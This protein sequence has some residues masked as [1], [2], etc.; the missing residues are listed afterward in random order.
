MELSAEMK[1][2]LDELSRVNGDFN[3]FI[4]K[5][6][7]SLKSNSFKDLKSSDEYKLQAWPTFLKPQTK[8]L[9]LEMGT[10]VFDL[11]KSIPG[12]FFANDPHRAAA[13]FEQPAAV[14][15]LQL[16]G[17]NHDHLA[18]L[19]GRVDFIFSTAGLKCLELNVSATTIGWQLPGWEA[20]YLNNPVIAKFLNEYRV[21]INNEN[22]PALFLD[23]MIRFTEPLAAPPDTAGN[24]GHDGQSELNLAMVMQGYIESEQAANPLWGNLKSLYHEK[25]SH[26]SLTG[27][28]M[29]CDFP[30]LEY[31]DNKIYFKGRRIHGVIELCHGIVAPGVMKAYMAGNIRLLNGPMTGLLSNK[32]N[33]ALLS[34]HE[35]SDIFTSAER[36]TIKKYIPWTRKIIPG[37]TVYKG[38]KIN[39]PDFLMAHKDKLVIKPSLGLGG[40]RVC[41]GQDIFRKEWEYLVN[42]ALRKKNY[43]VQELVE[44][45][46]F[47]YRFG[48][49]GFAFHDIVWGI[50]LLGPQY[51][52]SFIRLLPSGNARKVVNAAQGAEI[53]IIF[54]V[55]E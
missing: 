9:F 54:E 29:M 45:P 37:E 21:K 46:R 19:V 33:L 27:N 34:E 55:D 48:E 52:A 49:D 44:A 51:G 18:N 17:I 1:A 32:L 40:Q 50:W 47:P 11:I 39:L 10:K 25:L 2:T 12:R 38:E 6:P 14:I 20:L 31:I 3:G 43:V 8:A 4:K 53:G 7:E 13:F 35:N 36:E 15:K 28:L 16:D 23:H 5:N 22:Y 26:R 41:I 24:A 30:D 42:M